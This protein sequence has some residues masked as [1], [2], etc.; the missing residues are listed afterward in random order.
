MRMREV[1]KEKNIVWMEKSNEERKERSRN[2]TK[3]VKW[4]K[5]FVYKVK[6]DEREVEKMG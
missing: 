1:V 6:G 2:G 4:N 5:L 3:V